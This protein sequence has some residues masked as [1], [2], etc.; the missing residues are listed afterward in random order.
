MASSR[1]RPPVAA[2]GRL[3]GRAPPARTWRRAGRRPARLRCEG[4]GA[5][6]RTGRPGWPACAPHGTAGNDRTEWYGVRDL[7]TV[8]DLT[9][10]WSGTPLGTLA[11]I[12]PPVTFGY[13]AVPPTPHPH[14]LDH[15]D[16]HPQVDRVLEVTTR[17]ARSD[18]TAADE[19]AAGAAE[20]P[21]MTAFLELRVPTSR[22]VAGPGSG[23]LQPPRGSAHCGK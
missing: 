3:A 10:T 16:R 2:A 13:A 15:H 11:P 12:R 8:T 4:A 18:L 20:P 9:A 17:T 21:V 5:L 7:H 1:T 22:V 14:P 23:P 6:R 19:C